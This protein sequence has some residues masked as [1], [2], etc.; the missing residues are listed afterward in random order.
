MRPKKLRWTPAVARI[1]EPH[2]GDD[3]AIL[4]AQVEAGESELYLYPGVGVLMTR[5]EVYPDGRQEL[6]L[7]SGIGRG[8]RPVLP[9]LLDEARARG[10]DVVRVHS[11]R[12]GMGRYLRAC[13][14]DDGAERVYRCNLKNEGQEQQ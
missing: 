14:F 4:R 10:V 12:P 6:V 3:A 9:G 2:L 5:L 7:I 11:S 8:A 13:G 1:L